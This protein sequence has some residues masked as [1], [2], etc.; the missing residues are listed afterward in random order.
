MGDHILNSHFSLIRPPSVSPPLWQLPP[1]LPSSSLA[2][3]QWE[4]LWEDPVS[5]EVLDT[6]QSW[7]HLLSWEA[8]L[9]TGSLEVTQSKAF[10]STVAAVADHPSTTHGVGANRVRT[11]GVVSSGLVG[12]GGLVGGVGHGVVGGFGHGVGVGH[13]LVGGVGH[14][15]VGGVGH[16]L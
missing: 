7:E 14:G 9:A 6:V 3:V 2:T 5:L 12:H 4:A 8:L 13:G 10:G 1:P 15:L 11:V 16:G